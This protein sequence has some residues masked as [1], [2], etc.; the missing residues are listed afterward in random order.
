MRR[1]ARWPPLTAI[2][3]AENAFQGVIEA[4]WPKR[5]FEIEAGQKNFGDASLH[6][7]S[8]QTSLKKLISSSWLSSSLPFY[9]PLES[10]IFAPAKLA[11][12]VFRFM[13]SDCAQSCQEESDCAAQK[14]NIREL[15]REPREVVHLATSRRLRLVYSR[16]QR[17]DHP[18]IRLALS[19][20]APCI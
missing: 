4:G 9:S 20:P 14:N 8:F 12:R 15:N 3:A 18:A 2:Q 1:R 5:G 19:M 10:L 16:V 13:Y 6:P 17:A 11:E 7:R